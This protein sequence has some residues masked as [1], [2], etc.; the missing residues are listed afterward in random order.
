MADQVQAEPIDPDSHAILDASEHVTIKLGKECPSQ[1]V[2]HIHDLIT[3]IEAE[4]KM[5]IGH[6]V[7][8]ITARWHRQ[9]TNQSVLAE[10][11]Q[12]VVDGGRADLTP[13]RA[14][15]VPQFLGRRVGI[16]SIQAHEDGM[17][18]LGVANPM[19][20]EDPFGLNRL[21]GRFIV[22]PRLRLGNPSNPEGPFQPS[23][24]IDSTHEPD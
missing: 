20:L 8:P 10:Q 1:I 12:S 3:V 22:L 23:S 17:P 19:F 21:H 24:S 2:G 11:I 18:S 4:V 15:D 13:L 5:V 6:R 7:V 9:T 14:N 16:D